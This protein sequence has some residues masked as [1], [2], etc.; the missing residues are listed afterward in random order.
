MSDVAEDLARIARSV[1]ARMPESGPLF[2][3]PATAAAVAQTEAAL[4]FSLP[5]DVRALYELA[6]GQADGPSLL[7]AF[8]LMSLAE[9]VEAAAF[10]NDFF[11]DGYNEENPDHA[12]IEPDAGIKPTWWSPYW[13]PLMTN[14]GGDYY[15]ADLD[16]ADGGTVGQIIAYFHDEIFRLH[17]ASSVASLLHM[18]AE[19]LEDG[20]LSI[21]DGMITRMAND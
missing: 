12:P 11:P 20:S 21:F 18:V 15:C 5:D 3:S 16:P 4:G 19:G 8:S 7:N 10:L 1:A 13:V 14:D 9:M 6:D 2:A 17:I